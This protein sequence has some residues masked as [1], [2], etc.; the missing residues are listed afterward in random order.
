MSEPKKP[1]SHA[2]EPS[3]K[4]DVDKKAARKGGSHARKRKLRLD[5]IAAV[6]VPFLLIVL[7]I[8]ALCFHSCQ[9]RKSPEE[10]GSTPVATATT[11]AEKVENSEKDTQ[12]DAPDVATDT[13]KTT[14]AEESSLTDGKQITLAAKGVNKGDLILIN[15]DH[16]YDFPTGDPKLKSVYENRNSSYSVSDMEVQ[17]D[18]ETIQHL[19]EMMA[20]FEKETGLSGMQVFSG[21]RDKA[22]QDARYADGS[23][24]FKGGTS[25]Y[26]SGRSFNLKIN[27]GDGTSDYYNAEKYPQYSWIA[28]HAAEYGFVVRYPDG[29]EEKTGE[30][31]RSYTFRYVGVPHAVYMTEHKL[32]L[33]EY[34]DKIHSYTPAN[35]LEITADGKQYKVFYVGIG[36]TNDV[37]VTIP[38]KTYT[39]SGDNISGYIVTCE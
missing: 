11:S 8:G 20:A 24:D 30:D 38:G 6:G 17:L 7:L 23:T 2:K 32:C 26:H 31:S 27:F 22:D 3:P 21:Y 34:V 37:D 5:R 28:E 39:A 25:D 13:T 9:C 14:Q 16:S 1:I 35:P 36:G 12:T 4:P 19:N 18:A 15:K 33:E 29:K 10:S